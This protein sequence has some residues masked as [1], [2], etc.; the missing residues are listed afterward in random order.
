MNVI[1]FLEE[2]E[3]IYDTCIDSAQSY[4][5]FFD[6]LYKIINQEGIMACINN[7]NRDKQDVI[8]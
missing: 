2:I 4:Y 6:E 8:K 7:I 3:P 1:N 5:H